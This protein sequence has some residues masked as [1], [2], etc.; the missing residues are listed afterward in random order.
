MA[1]QKAVAAAQS[2]KG[3]KR[4]DATALKPSGT[5]SQ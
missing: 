3:V 2:I 5:T 1:V 4:V